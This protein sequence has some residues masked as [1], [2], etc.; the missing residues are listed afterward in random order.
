M[1]QTDNF[2][3]IKFLNIPNED[4]LYEELYDT[5]L[6]PDELNNL[7]QNEEYAEILAFHRRRRDFV[8]D[9]TPPLQTSWSKIMSASS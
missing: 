8:I 4:I 5:T 7:A 3:Y 6:D 1:I 9:N 2:K